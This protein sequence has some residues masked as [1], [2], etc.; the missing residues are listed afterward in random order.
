MESSNYNTSAKEVQQL[1]EVLRYRKVSHLPH[2]F[3]SDLKC[4]AVSKFRNRIAL[5]IVNI[6]FI[7][8]TSM[9]KLHYDS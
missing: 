7:I 5:D 3:G 9:T 8:M 6:S 2:W 1:V 4:V